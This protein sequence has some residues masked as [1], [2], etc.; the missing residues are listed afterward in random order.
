MKEAKG[1]KVLQEVISPEN[2]LEMSE[3]IAIK[4]TKHLAV[5]IGRYAYKVHTDLYHDLT[6]KNR[7]NYV[8]TNSYDLVQSVAVFLCEHFGEYLDDY[9]RMSQLGSELSLKRHC[10]QIVDSLVCKRYRG[11]MKYLGFEDLTFDQEPRYEMQENVDFT[12]SEQKVEHIIDCLQLTQMQKD[13]L[14]YRM[15]GASFSEIGRYLNRC[16][17]TVFEHLGKVRM[18][19]LKFIEEME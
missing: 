6:N 15:L 3:M 10:Y 19:Y 17:S 12:A 2:V 16:Q 14:S 18:K 8:F 5:W 7:P 11:T 9:Y 13:V 4:A 1:F